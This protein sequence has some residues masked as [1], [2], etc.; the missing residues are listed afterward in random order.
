MSLARLH[1]GDHM[2]RGLARNRGEE[3]IGLKGYSPAPMAAGRD[4]TCL[5][6]MQGTSPQEVPSQHL[7]QFA[8]HGLAGSRWFKATALK[9]WPFAPNNASCG[10][11]FRALV[12]SMP[13]A[14]GPSRQSKTR[15]QESSSSL[16]GAS[17]W[18]A[19][20]CGF[21]PAGFV[22]VISD[23]KCRTTLNVVRDA[24][25]TDGKA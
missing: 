7:T 9:S 17:S 14:S 22:V 23:S 19:N 15:G 12:H 18:D 24:V 21:Q 1:S 25:A 20:G 4:R 6:R 10:T 3:R 13:P 5:H 2:L 16:A 11:D 8:C